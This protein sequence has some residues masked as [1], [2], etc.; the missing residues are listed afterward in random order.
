MKGI[1]RLGCI[2]PQERFGGNRM[3]GAPG[4]GRLPHAQTTPPRLPAPPLPWG[5]TQD[6]SDRSDDRAHREADE[7]ATAHPEGNV[8]QSTDLPR[9]GVVVGNGEPSTLPQE[10]AER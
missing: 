5:M 2:L 8:P 1:L 9:Q 3:S 7:E 10:P 4:G 6:A